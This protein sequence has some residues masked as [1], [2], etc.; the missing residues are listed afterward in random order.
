MIDPLNDSLLTLKE[1]ANICPRLKGKKP[2]FTSLWR[3]IKYGVHGHHLESVRVGNLYCTT[4]VALAEFFRAL[5]T[6]PTRER[7][8][9]TKMAKPRTATHREKAVAEARK[10]L[11][12]RG[13]FK[14]RTRH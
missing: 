7:A 11:E 5:A 14:G 3:W 4:E 8:T 2:H 13:L 12:A 9:I 10:R 6:V 1:A